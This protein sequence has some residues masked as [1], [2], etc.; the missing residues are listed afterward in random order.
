MF[1]DAASRHIG[2]GVDRWRWALWLECYPVDKLNGKT[3]A[4]SG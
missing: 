3:I 2:F 4:L 1:P